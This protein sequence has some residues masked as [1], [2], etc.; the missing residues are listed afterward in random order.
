MGVGVVVVVGVGVTVG[1]TWAVCNSTTEP[2][3]KLHNQLCHV[4]RVR[5]VCY[6]CPEKVL[7]KNCQ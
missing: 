4:G 1:G 7:R 3:H 6:T 2:T 5:S